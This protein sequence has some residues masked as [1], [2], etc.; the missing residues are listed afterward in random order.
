MA[1]LP[2]RVLSVGPSAFARDFAYKRSAIGGPPRFEVGDDAI[3]DDAI[4]DERFRRL[5][6][7]D[8]RVF[9]RAAGKERRAH[10][11]ASTQKPPI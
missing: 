9:D 5:N 11:A 8:Y 4:E 3:R 6:Q 10:Q 1:I 2:T 7:V